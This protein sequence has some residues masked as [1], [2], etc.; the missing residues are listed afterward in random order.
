ML[1]DFI[2]SLM[3]L[4]D[5]DSLHLKTNW[6]HFYMYMGPFGF[7]AHIDFVLPSVKLQIVIKTLIPILLPT[8]SVYLLIFSR[9]EH[10]KFVENALKSHKCT[11]ST[12]LYTILCLF[13]FY[14]LPSISRNGCFVWNNISPIGNIGSLNVHFKWSNKM[15]KSFCFDCV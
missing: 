13:F 2:Q 15:L 14:L 10:Q 9:D 11:L 6:F 4:S 7:F 5:E 1:K 3:N 8:Y 12:P